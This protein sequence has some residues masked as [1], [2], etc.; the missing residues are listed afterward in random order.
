M[1]DAE[2]A[3][4]EGEVVG[5]GPPRCAACGRFKRKQWNGEWRCVRESFVRYFDAWEHE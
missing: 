3:Q 2:P 1:T 5:S 4:R